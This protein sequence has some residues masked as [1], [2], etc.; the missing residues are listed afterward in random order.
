MF[1][2]IKN[3]KLFSKFIFRTVSITHKYTHPS[4]EIGMKGFAAIIL[5]YLAQ[6]CNKKFLPALKKEVRSSYEEFT[7]IIDALGVCSHSIPDGILSLLHK[8]GDVNLIFIPK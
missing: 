5:P 4:K 7:T 6:A 3:N 2:K 1:D 8:S